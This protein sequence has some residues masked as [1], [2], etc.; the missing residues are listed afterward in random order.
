MSNYTKVFKEDDIKESHFGMAIAP[1]FCKDCEHFYKSKYGNYVEC[2]KK[3]VVPTKLGEWQ[4]DD[5]KITGIDFAKTEKKTLEFREANKNNDCEYFVQRTFCNSH[6]F[7]IKMTLLII[8]FY[9]LVGFLCLLS[10]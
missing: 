4:K 5:K 6:S 10:F 9:S 7:E 8:A 2:E 3:I 1:V